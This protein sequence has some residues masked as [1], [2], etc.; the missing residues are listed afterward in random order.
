[1]VVGEQD[2]FLLLVFVPDHDP[3]KE[4]WAVVLGIES[5]KPNQLIGYDVSVGGNR[6][7]FYHHIVSVFLQSGDKEDASRCPVGKQG[8]V[9]VS[10][11]DHHD[12]AWS[13][14]DSPSNRDLMSF[15]L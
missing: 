15:S 12:R 11:V 5:S 14:R 9:I 3:A 4:I 13:E 1:M 8:V 2:D 10:P 7:I 6:T